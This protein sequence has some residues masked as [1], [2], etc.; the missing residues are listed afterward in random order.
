MIIWKTGGE[1][2]LVC[3][4]S[5]RFYFIFYF[6]FLVMVGAS[7]APVTSSAA[8]QTEPLVSQRSSRG[9]P[10]VPTSQHAPMS[11]AT[12]ATTTPTKRKFADETRLS[13]SILNIIKLGKH[14]WFYFLFLK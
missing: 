5:C 14:S 9:V 13:C 6:L 11:S 7:D 10:K 12:T 2:V 3:T 8:K 4:S 1:R